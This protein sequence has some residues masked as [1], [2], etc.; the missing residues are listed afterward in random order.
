ML[1][2][3]EPFTLLGFCGSWVFG[4]WSCGWCVRRVLGQTALEIR[5]ISDVRL[6]GNIE[7]LFVGSKKLRMDTGRWTVRM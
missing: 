6:S 4:V 1:C 5:R 7:G 3:I 2:D